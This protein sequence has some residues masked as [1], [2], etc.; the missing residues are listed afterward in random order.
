MRKIIAIAIIAIASPAAAQTACFSGDYGCQHRQT[1]DRMHEFH[2]QLNG[3]YGA[4]P[5]QPYVPQPSR[6]VYDDYDAVLG[7]LR[8]RRERRER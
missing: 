5:V 3:V 4:Q 7:I 8:D 6:R 1:H 2:M